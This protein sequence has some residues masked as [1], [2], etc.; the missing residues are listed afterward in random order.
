MPAGEIIGTV[1]GHASGHGFV[2]RDDGE[3]DVH[4]SSREMAAV[5]HGDHVRV[6]LMG[7]DRRGR[8][9]GRVVEILR[10][11][12]RLLIG[13]LLQEDGH[14]LLAPEDRRYGRDVLIPKR[15]L[16][17]AQD[18]QVV[19]VELTEPPAL[20]GQ[21]V[22]RV[23]EVLGEVDDP[24]M[25]VE[26]AVRKFGIPH[27]FSQA[28][29]D[30]AQ[31]LPNK[32]RSADRQGRVDLGDVAFVTIDGEDARDFDD[33]VYCEPAVVT[34]RGRKPNGWRLLVAIADVSHYVHDGD[35]IN[36]D[37]YARATSVYFPRRVVPMLPEKLS[38]GLCSLN[39]DMDRLA[40]VCDM[41]VSARGKIH[42]YQFYPAVIRSQGRLTYDQV[43]A[44]LTPD[45]GRSQPLDN[46]ELL[47]HLRHLHGAFQSLLQARQR[48][49]A[50]DF[51]TVETQIICDDQG[52]VTSIEPSPRN[53]A[54][55]LIEECMLAAN[56]CC[57][58]FVR[59][60]KDALALYRVHEPPPAEKVEALR[61]YLRALDVKVSVGDEPSPQVFQQIA[62][63]T[64]DR[65]DAEQ[66]QMQLLR[67][68]SQAVYKPQNKGHFGLAYDAYMHFTSPI[69][70]YP[71]LLAHR[72]I[73]ALLDERQYKLPELPE[74]GE[75]EA[76]F[77]KRLQKRSGEPAQE[78]G[79]K[80][81]AQAQRWELAGLHCSACE[82]RA[83]EAS[84]D[85]EAWL[86]CQYMRQYLGEVFA[87]TVTSATSFGLFVSLDELY[88]E[89]LVHIS[90]LGDEYFQFDEVRQQIRGEQSGTAYAIGTPVRV[91]VS[92]VDLDARQIDFRLLADTPAADTRGSGK[93]QSAR[94][95]AHKPD[96]ANKKPAAAKA[97]SRT[98]RTAKKHKAR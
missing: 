33:A 7:H 50:I 68:M 36:A 35:A 78:S 40:L 17:S 34:G 18:G 16:A 4:L 85:V 60:H 3:P 19:V 76:E 71:D 80:T 64:R 47:P 59:Q 89:G 86:K 87:G 42:A 31:S 22:G 66:I 56:V 5:L 52:R 21:P 84:R 15:A 25:E 75:L 97:G 79:Q 70:R 11:G 14:W 77:A 69:R 92:R 53:D 49:G 81:G 6:K 55:R 63:A 61:A 96:K 91:Q 10:R 41:L 24:G 90:E 28:C 65:P 26:I 12:A 95:S 51:D 48:R 82:R 23:V 58:D 38:N 83:E 20:Y 73:K 62:D 88:V 13:R 54:H 46:A 72:V 43:A 8:P 94:K 30:T 32:V 67:A 1:Q 74:A 98:A 57:A 93:K 27:A 29:L 9:E 2:I 44:A 37:A 39:P 45:K